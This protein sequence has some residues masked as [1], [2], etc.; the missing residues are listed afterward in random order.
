MKP[1]APHPYQKTIRDF[2]LDTPRCGVWAGMGLGKTVSSATAASEIQMVDDAPILVL[3]PL[4]VARDTWPEEIRKWDHLSHLKV[5]PVIGSVKER[6]FALK[7]KADIYTTNY[8]NLVWLT[9]TLG[10]NWPFKT[11][12]A[13]ESTRL[14]SFRLRQGGKRAQSLGRVAHTKIQRFIELTGTP[15]PNGLIDLWGQAWFLD[16]GKRLGRTFTAF[17][18]RWFQSSFDGFG[19]SPLG[20]AQAE[21]QGA[22]RDVCLTVDAKDWFDLKEP[23]ITNLYVDLPVRAKALYKD[24]EREMFMQLD[25]HDIEAFNAAAR[26][27]KLLQIANGAV[28]LDPAVGE[29]APRGNRE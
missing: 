22:L 27:Q 25:E 16:A 10:E 4:R 7:Q 8:E 20:H 21:I 9:E 28:Y 2:I 15:S 5:S 1:Y 29:D 19:S 26:T 23:I 14:K 24:M 17:K 6:A 13:D 18:D 11:V 12:I 3:A